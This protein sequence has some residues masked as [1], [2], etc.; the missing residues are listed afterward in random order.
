MWQHGESRPRFLT[1]PV[2]KRTTRARAQ[3]HDCP[4]DERGSELAV[5]QNFSA[6]H[7]SQVRGLVITQK[8]SVQTR[9]IPCDHVL[10]GFCAVSTILPLPQTV[11]TEVTTS[12]VKGNG[13]NAPF[14]STIH[15]AAAEPHA[16]FLKVTIADGGHDVAF[17]S[18]V[19]GR[20]RHGYR[21]LLL[22]SLLGTRIELCYLF[23]K[24]TFTNELD[25]MWA[26]PRQVRRSRAILLV[27]PTRLRVRFVVL[28]A[29]P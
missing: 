5:R 2:V 24:I 14:R 13:M 12:V 4:A 10:A 3:R 25:N 26:S 6:P 8:S 20:L 7:R 15:C 18:A 23:L 17:E 1:D 21:V 28:S 29:L 19:L 9:H 27:A 11:E 16:T 22:R